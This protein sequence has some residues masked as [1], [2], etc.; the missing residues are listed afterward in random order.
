[1]AA[2]LAAFAA[3]ASFRR[4]DVPALLTPPP[5]AFAPWRAVERDDQVAE[6]VETFPSAF[7]SGFPENDTVP[8]R[9]LVPANATG[10]VPVVLVTHY[11]G[12]SDLRAE[13]ALGED[14]A[15]RGVAAAILTLPYHMSRTPAGHRSGE[16]AIVPDMAKLRGSIAQAVLDVRRSLDFLDSRPEFTKAPRGISGTSLGAL[17][18]ALSYGIDPRLTHAAFI[19]GGVDFA[20]IVWDSSRVQPQREALRRQGVT[21]SRLRD[22]LKDV[23]PMTYLPRETPGTTLLISAKYDTVVPR[24]NSAALARALGEP[25]RLEIQTGH[26]GGIFIQQKALREVARFFGNEMTGVAYVPPKRLLAPTLRLGALLGAPNGFDLAA[27]I[28]VV[29]FDPRGD[30]FASLMITARGPQAFVGRTLLS[31]LA[32]GGIAK[33]SG[34]SHFGLGAFWSVVL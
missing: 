18:A 32:L 26:Y 28:D 20:G 22:A 13:R 2:A 17:L 3:L 25:R 31:G 29:H 33:L 8:L 21:E 19:L 4:A 27:G 34:R 7:V 1:M 16:L 24:A 23:E 5:I 30:G 12:A 6:Y 9:I 11:L 15:A 10:P 14:L